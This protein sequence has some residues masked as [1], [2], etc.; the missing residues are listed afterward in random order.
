M[1]ISF[2]ESVIEKLKLIRKLY[3]PK[4]KI[5]THENTYQ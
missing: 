5:Y 3:W 2:I 4:L 1:A